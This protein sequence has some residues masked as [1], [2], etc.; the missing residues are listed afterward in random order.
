MARENIFWSSESENSENE[1]ER[2]GVKTRSYSSAG[3]WKTL[4]TRLAKRILI[5]LFRKTKHITATSLKASSRH[6]MCRLS[7]AGEKKVILILKRKVKLFQEALINDKSVRVT[8]NFEEQSPG[9]TDSKVCESR[10]LGA[11]CDSTW[12]GLPCTCVDLRWL[13][14]TLVTIKF[15]RKSTQV[16]T[17]WPSWATYNRC[18]S[19]P[20]ANEIQVM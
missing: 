10:K 14:L 7:S 4:E 20:L 17:V 15:A 2:S 11:T 9:Q 8:E 12:S 5:Y 19:G 3:R 1:K 18:Y 16:F 6:F 13:A